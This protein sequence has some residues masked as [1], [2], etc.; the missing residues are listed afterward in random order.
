[1]LI[2]LHRFAMSSFQPINKARRTSKPAAE[3]NSP[4][5]YHEPSPALEAY[6]SNLMRASSSQAKPSKGKKRKSPAVVMPAKA[7]PQALV[8]SEES[9]TTQNPPRKKRKTV[10]E[11]SKAL[12]KQAPRDAKP[13]PTVE[14]SAESTP[15]TGAESDGDWSKSS[16]H[17]AELDSDMSLQTL[18]RRSPRHRPSCVS[19]IELSRAIQCVDSS[20]STRPQKPSQHEVSGDAIKREGTASRDRSV[21]RPRTM[22]PSD[23]NKEF[24]DKKLQEEGLVE[25]PS[26]E[27]AYQRYKRT[28]KE[29]EKKIQAERRSWKKASRK[30]K[31][32]EPECRLE[33]NAG[34]ASEMPSKK[35]VKADGKTHKSRKR[36]KQ[37]HKRVKEEPTDVEAGPQPVQNAASRSEHPP[38]GPRRDQSGKPALSKKPSKVIVHEDLQPEAVV[39]QTTSEILSSRSKGSLSSEQMARAR[40]QSSIE[41][42][43]FYGKQLECPLPPTFDS[44]PSIT[45]KGLIIDNKHRDAGRSETA[46]DRMTPPDS[47]P[48]R[49]GSHNRQKSTGAHMP[50]ETNFDN[51]NRNPGSADSVDNQSAPTSPSQD[52]RGVMDV[53]TK[54]RRKTLSNHSSATVT[55]DKVVERTSKEVREESKGRP[56]PGRSFNLQRHRHKSVPASSIS[57]TIT[58]NE[59]N[60]S[61]Q[62]AQSHRDYALQELSNNAILHKLASVE[63]VLLERLPATPRIQ[64]DSD[65]PAPAVTAAAAV[66]DEDERPQQRRTKRVSDA[67]RQL[68]RPKLDRHVPEHLRLPDEDIVNI[69]RTS[70]RYER[71]VQ[72]PYAFSWRGC[73]Y[74]PYKHLFP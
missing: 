21:I 53:R 41:P 9:R 28:K 6:A 35:R 16:E 55:E 34:N 42:Y 11:T 22:S 17:F 18:N 72:A 5:D 56:Q 4:A 43:S 64:N 51:V 39:L 46:N 1:M 44:S 66:G 69:R 3:I 25:L 19:S 49:K 13:L 24:R 37:S 52:N 26:A 33:G 14:H 54:S 59:T 67:E 15:V 61:P 8:S 68:Q 36:H 47:S 31:G 30:Q 29:C 20:P 12:R 74:A 32:K 40:Q 38:S 7:P 73:V 63:K 2:F 10:K 45:D 60:A 62:P 58:L 57:R 50:L 27:W 48:A 71:H 65:R 23:Y 70:S